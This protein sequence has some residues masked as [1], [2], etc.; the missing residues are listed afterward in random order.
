MIRLT[1]RPVFDRTITRQV[2]EGETVTIGSHTYNSTGN[3]T[4]S[5]QTRFG[6]DSVIHL[7]LT[8]LQEL[9]SNFDLQICDGQSYVF[10]SQTLNT[11][12]TYTETFA[13]QAGCDSVV[14]LNL[15]V[16][17]QITTTLDEQICEGDVFIWALHPIQRPAP[18][19][20]ISHRWQVATV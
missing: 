16:V 13:S 4:D 11:S 12:G 20:A 5:L 2:C 3:Y 18:I 14:T 19:P 1:V 8:V 17:P 7:N 15:S 9:V 10:G 6:C